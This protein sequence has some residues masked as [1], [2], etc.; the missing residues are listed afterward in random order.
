MS[1]YLNFAISLS[2]VW[3]NRHNL[4]ALSGLCQCNY[5]HHSEAIA[6]WQKHVTPVLVIA[7]A[8]RASY[9][10]ALPILLRCI[11]VVKGD[12]IGAWVYRLSLLYVPLPYSSLPL[13]ESLGDFLIT[14]N[15]LVLSW[16]DGG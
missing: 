2:A 1:F 3:F 13:L 9:R 7:A 5:L 11:G 6:P 8:I 4:F 14:G 15:G 16:R 10:A 12:R